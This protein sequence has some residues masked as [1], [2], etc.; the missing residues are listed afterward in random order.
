MGEWIQVCTKVG[1]NPFLKGDNSKL[2]KI[3]QY[4]WHLKKKCLQNFNQ[5]WHKAIW[6]KG[7][8]V[9]SNG[10]LHNSKSTLATFKNLFQQNHWT[11]DN[12]NQT[13]HR[14]FL[15][16]RDLCLLKWWTTYFSR[17]DNSKITKK[18]HWR[19]FRIVFSRTNGPFSAK[20]DRQHS[21]VKGIQLCS[22]ESHT[23]SLGG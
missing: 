18:K 17:G 14:A 12:F 11:N 16:E 9:Y 2:A 20:L 8:Q 5:T 4:N 6:V 15:G 22:I 7:I 3:H 23:L 21:L 19:Y 1:P 10:R 13:W